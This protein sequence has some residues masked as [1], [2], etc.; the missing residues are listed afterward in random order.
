M[1]KRKKHGGLYKQRDRNGKELPYWTADYVDASGKRRRRSTHCEIKADAKRVRAS[2]VVEAGKGP[3]V[4]HAD[5]VTFRELVDYLEADYR[6]KGN[7]SWA[8]ADRALAHLEKVFGSTRAV[9]ITA[10]RLCGYDDLRM[11]QGVS[12]STRKYEL[13]V[14]RRMFHVAVKRGKLNTVPAFPEI[15]VNNAREEYITDD[16]L[17]ALQ[18]ELPEYLRG[19]AAFRTCT[20]MRKQESLGLRWDQV[21]MKAGVIRLLRGTTKNR[22]PRTFPFH[23]YPTL[24]AVIEDQRVRTDHWERV[25]GQGISWLFHRQGRQIKS[26][27]V[28]WRSACRRA[29]VLGADGRH[30]VMHDFRRSAVRRMEQDGIPRSVAM[31]LTGHLTENVYRRYAV[32]SEGDLDAATAKLGVSHEIGIATARKRALHIA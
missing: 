31:K 19:Y 13:A 26:Y 24:A 21:D 11:G 25:T 23:N 22:E 32:V 1:T 30:K 9:E 5:Q 2:W 4:E 15:V 14:L 10:N 12:A 7:A 6:R 8:R 18:I 28:A 3:A 27:D 17:V 16:D 20:G 29:G